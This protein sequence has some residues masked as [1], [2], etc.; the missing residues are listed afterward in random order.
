M[1]CS[2]YRLRS[3]YY[4]K[5]NKVLSVKPHLISP[6]SSDLTST[7]TGVRKDSGDRSDAC[8][9]LTRNIPQR[10]SLS[11][12]QRTWT[13]RNL[14]PPARVDQCPSGAP[15]PGP[16]RPRTRDPPSVTTPV[17][18]RLYQVGRDSW[19]VYFESLSS[20]TAKGTPADLCDGGKSNHN[21]NPSRPQICAVTRGSLSDPRA[22]LPIDHSL[23]VRERF[24]LPSRPSVY[25]DFRLSPRGSHRRPDVRPSLHPSLPRTGGRPWAPLAKIDKKEVFSETLRHDRSARRFTY[26]EEGV[27]Y[28]LSSLCFRGGLPDLLSRGALFFHGRRDPAGSLETPTS[29]ARTISAHPSTPTTKVSPVRDGRP[30]VPPSAVP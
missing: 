19:F 27:P 29:V 20:P 16:T 24:S 4:L 23:C 15:P 22:V 18:L 21:P 28:A 2:K 8:R 5:V 11:G 25:R 12:R 9:D 7:T 17:T 13:T 14:H 10:W 3:L 6:P 1:T 30:R 26:T